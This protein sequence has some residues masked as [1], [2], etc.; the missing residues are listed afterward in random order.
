MRLKPYLFG[1]A[2]AVAL[3]VWAEEPATPTPSA[4]P[5]AATPPAQ[6]EPAAATP[7]AQGEPAT[8][9][10]PAQG[11]TATP[12]PTGTVARAQFT[13]GIQDHEPI[14]DLTSLTNDKTHLFYFTELKD[15][16]GQTVK[17]RWEHDGNV[18]AEV[19]FQVSGNRWRVWS[20]KNLDPSWLGEWKV[21]VVDGNGATLSVNTFTYRK[22]EAAKVEAPAVTTP[23]P[24]PQQQ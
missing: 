8:A 12:A 4:E 24:A 7:P 14:D 22:A 13:S 1:L 21:S 16:A 19:P 10:P 23:A 20:S 2:V 3:P 6:G 17:H 11:E 15:L 5:A 18:M 9:T